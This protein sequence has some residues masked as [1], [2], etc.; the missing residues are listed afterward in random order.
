[1]Q[2]WLRSYHFYNGWGSMYF[3]STSLYHIVGEFYWR[4]PHRWW[5]IM[6]SK[7]WECSTPLKHIWH[8]IISFVSTMTYCLLCLP[9]NVFELV[10]G[11]AENSIV[12]WVL[13]LMQIYK[14]YIN[15]VCGEKRTKMWSCYRNQMVILNAYDRT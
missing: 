7:W 11:H 9:E 15:S 4:L 1:M 14:V 10:A 5:A 6:I 2:F 3:E 13:S 12:L 8:E